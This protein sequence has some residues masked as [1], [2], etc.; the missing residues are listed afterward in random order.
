MYCFAAAGTLEKTSIYT[1]EH[2]VFPNV[3][4]GNEERKV[5]GDQRVE[6]CR[7]DFDGE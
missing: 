6:K 2:E 3:H 4:L 1:W 7:Q 5:L